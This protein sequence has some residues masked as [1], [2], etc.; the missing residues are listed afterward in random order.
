MW[1]GETR[2]TTRALKMAASNSELAEFS[3]RPSDSLTSEDVEIQE[4]T[5]KEP[6]KKPSLKEQAAEISLRVAKRALE[7]NQT[8]DTSVAKNADEVV[9]S[10]NSS[11]SSGSSRS[12][13]S[14]SNKDGERSSRGVNKPASENRSSSRKDSS[15]NS[16]STASSNDGKSSSNGKGK[17]K[18]PKQVKSRSHDVLTPI[19]DA[20]SEMLGDRQGKSPEREKPLKKKQ[21]LNSGDSDPGNS[22]G[23]DSSLNLSAELLGAINNLNKS[24]NSN[25]GGVQKG[26]EGLTSSMNENFVSLAQK[27][28]AS[29]AEESD[30]ESS[31]G[32]EGFSSEEVEQE[33]SR[34]IDHPIS[35]DSEDE[36]SF[37]SPEKPTDQLPA[38]IK[39]PNDGDND[40][41]SVVT[42]TKSH[43]L[44]SGNEQS[45]KTSFFARKRAEIKVVKDTGDKI[46]EDLAIIIEDR[47]WGDNV[48]GK[49][50]F[51]EIM[52]SVVRPENVPSLEAP[53]VRECL[54]V[55]LPEHVRAREKWDRLTQANLITVWRSLTLVI[56]ELGTHEQEAPWVV[57]I[58]EKL[59]DVISLAGF[60][61]KF[62]FISHR[63]EVVKQALAKEFK[64][65]GGKNYP[66]TPQ[67]LFGG[68]LGESVE[69]IVKENK[70]TERI[71]SENKP[72]SNQNAN[73]KSSKGPKFPVNKKNKGK[74][75]FH[76]GKNRKDSVEYRSPLPPGSDQPPVNFEK[77]N[78]APR[79]EN[80]R[81]NPNAG[82]V[83]LSIDSQQFKAGNIKFYLQN[84]E[85]I[86][87]D[88]DILSVV[89]GL[90]LTFVSPP[91]QE[92]KVREYKFDNQ[93][94]S[95]LNQEIQ[96]LIARGIISLGETS[97]AKFLSNVFS[98][99]K[100]NGK[101]RMILDLS[102][103]NDFIEKIHFKMDHLETAIAMMS[104]DCFMASI[105]LRDD[106]S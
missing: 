72:K 48:L 27:F 14:R 73:K 93:T 99:P 23:T 10:T 49:E 6:G 55:K 18:T 81:P 12:T 65:L 67:W 26:L 47:F 61:N 95:V 17:E 35:D 76:A 98:V 84:W 11:H 64:R 70:L 92:G 86:S 105:D 100:P 43:D 40:N 78:G 45:K 7:Q 60:V 29:R 19:L 90:K 87:S 83:S 50:K 4:I 38:T 15:R 31:D 69:Q 41:S 24:L 33:I 37:T 57:D 44:N 2:S 101:V 96:V 39:E 51:L 59:L 80:H 21:K 106:S 25:F 34:V 5:E 68:D 103:L 58:I 97:T 8:K 63:R 32:S 102:K 75:P 56:N 22:K 74:R 79:K 28:N 1:Q 62:N 42:V 91:V 13:R 53:S 46:D 71:F 16:S 88:Q 9:K 82:G 85:K 89:R 94:F 77:T 52:S 66:P 20:Q 54:W 30:D 3:D 104:P 36:D